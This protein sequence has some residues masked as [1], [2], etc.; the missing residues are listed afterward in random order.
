MFKR[1]QKQPGPG[2]EMRDMSR[3]MID[4]RTHTSEEWLAKMEAIMKE[5][6]APRPEIAA[7]NAMM[8]KREKERAKE[9]EKQRIEH[10]QKWKKEL[11][12]RTAKWEKEWGQRTA[13]WEK[14]IAKSNKLSAAM[15]QRLARA[16]SR[17][18]SDQ[19][20]VTVLSLKP[21]T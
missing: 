16:S 14:L 5:S 1:K 15:R 12:Q 8:A 18:P 9:L 6:Q 20:D 19:A 7:I 21:T 13:K 10:D 3:D 17:P 11:E 2:R 4:A